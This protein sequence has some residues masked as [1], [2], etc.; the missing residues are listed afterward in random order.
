MALNRAAIGFIWAIGSL[1]P[2][3]VSDAAIVYVDDSAV[4][5]LNNGAAWQDAYLDLHLALNSAQAGDEVRIGQGLYKPN[6]PGGHRDASFQLRSGVTVQGGYAGLNAPDPDALDP[7]LF[8]TTL[9]GDLN[10]DDGPNF[11]NYGDNSYHVVTADGV[12]STAMLRGV[13]IRGGNADWPSDYEIDLRSMAGGLICLNEGAPTLVDCILRDNRAWSAAG[14]MLAHGSA[15]TRCSFIHNEATDNYTGALGGALQLGAGHSVLIDCVFESNDGEHGGACYG[16]SQGG[17]AHFRRCRFIG[18]SAN[19]AGGAILGGNVV[20][21]ECDF[22]GNGTAHWGGAFQGGDAAFLSCRFLNNGAGMYGGAFRTYGSLTLVNCL[23]LGNGAANSSGAGEAAGPASIVN[24]TVV[25]NY[26]NWG[27]TGGL[28]LSGDAVLLNSL[29]WGNEADDKS[30]QLAAQVTVA[31]DQVMT[32]IDSCIM[33]WDGSVDGYG[34]FGDDPLLIDPDGADDVYGTEDDDAR[35]GEDSPCRDEGYVALLPPDEHDLDDDGDTVEPLP[36][37]L[38]GLVRTANG[39]VDI[40]AYEHQGAACPADLEPASLGDG[41]VNVDDLIAVIGNWG[42]CGSSE[43]HA[44]I[45]ND[46]AINIDDLLFV[47]LHWGDC[48]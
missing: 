8:E 16:P 45:T 43:C 35:L 40:G 38:G 18:N 15:L 10:S 26:A 29:V 21:V 12:D 41:Q 2:A 39:L 37:D 14:A 4:R 33:G 23:L 32:F 6:V 48:P 5:G 44:D 25:G 47:I 22:I 17:S 13:T 7:A 36:L 11:A 1:L 30:N 9:S 31:N 42:P 28:T 19:E 20:A 24:C 34:N 3:A 27:G 46:G